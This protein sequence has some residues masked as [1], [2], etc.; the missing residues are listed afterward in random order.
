MLKFS[1]LQQLEQECFEKM[2]NGD[3][4]SN[5]TAAANGRWLAI[6]TTLNCPCNNLIKF[7]QERVNL[8]EILTETT[9]REIDHLEWTRYK[10]AEIAY[11]GLL[12]QIEL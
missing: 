12:R 6:Y 8:Y 4:N 5:I 9:D 10:A 2:I 11:K 3:K 1:K 7:L